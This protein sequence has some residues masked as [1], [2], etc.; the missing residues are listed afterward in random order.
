MGLIVRFSLIAL[1]LYP[2]FSYSQSIL[3]T[4]GQ[5]NPRP[6]RR[7]EVGVQTDVI[8][9]QPCTTTRACPP[10][11]Q[12]VGIGPSVSVNL[13]SYLAIDADVTQA[14]TD[15]AHPMTYA[16]GSV[17][18]GRWLN[19]MAGPRLTAR[20]GRWGI[21][22]DAAVGAFSWSSVLKDSSPIGNFV[23]FP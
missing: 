12:R 8:P 10:S 14:V 5:A 13:N 15:D 1:L 4:S 3:P 20:S 17:A 6:L 9:F 23:P 22:L 11:P 16:D 2:S 19:I 18:G 7:F 21:F